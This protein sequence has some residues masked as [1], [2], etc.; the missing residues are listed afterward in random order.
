MSRKGRTLDGK[1]KWQRTNILKPEAICDHCNKDMAPVD[2]VDQ[3]HSYCGVRIRFKRW[4]SKLFMGFLELS[5]SNVLALAKFYLPNEPKSKM[6]IVRIAERIVEQM[7]ASRLMS[8]LPTVPN[9]EAHKGTHILPGTPLPGLSHSKYQCAAPKSRECNALVQNL[10]FCKECHG[11]C[12][13]PVC[14]DLLL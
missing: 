2:L 13:M 11:T 7:A 9:L 1:T 14:M 12:R 3:S 4:P 5:L 6:T 10:R 8:D